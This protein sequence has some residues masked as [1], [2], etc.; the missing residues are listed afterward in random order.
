MTVA[1]SQSRKTFA[2]DNVSTSFGTTPVVFFETS[3]LVIYVTDDTTG[4]ATT[5]VENTDY[6]VTGGDGAVGTVSL[7]GGSSPWGALQTGTTL[8]IVRELPIVQEADPEN[9]DLSD[10]DVIEQ[11]LDRATMVSQQLST[12]LDRSIVFDDSVVSTAS[13]T[14]PAPEAD[15]FLG[16]NDTA[17]AIENK[18][19]A[20]VSAISLPVAIADG[21]TGQITAPLALAALGGQSSTEAANTVLARS[22]GTS[23]AMAGV[24]LAASQLLG[25]GA[26]GNVAA[27][28]LG[29]GLSM[30][31]TTLN[32]AAA[33]GSVTASGYTQ[34]TSRLLGRTTASSGAIEEISVGTGLSLSSGTLSASSSST[35]RTQW[36]TSF[37]GTSVTQPSGAAGYL[38]ENGLYQFTTA[39]TP[40]YTVAS[41]S[42]DL[43]SNGSVRNE[44]GIYWGA[45]PTFGTG[46]KASA[47]PTMVVRTCP[48]TANATDRF[49]GLAGAQISAASAPTN[50][51][52]FRFNTSGNYIFVC[53]ASGTESTVDTGTAATAGTLVNLSFVSSSNGTSIQAYVNGV[54]AGSPITTNIPSAALGFSYS[55]GPN[56]NTVGLRV[57]EIF[58]EQD[59]E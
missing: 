37:Q 25:R 6:T 53:R 31:G 40:T 51:I 57:A 2:G 52:Y 29:T 13:T 44:G 19:I 45:T 59:M 36:R 56:T 46:W 55:N 58:I 17:T 14:L 48:L 12:R 24:A 42:L 33:S 18:T 23:G 28:A 20:D 16:W 38:T 10:A 15:A 43:T 5:L 3:N 27:I 35:T 8:V 30:S 21:G 11:A 50:G 26:S 41:H 32:G 54:A 4:V 47:D 7:A 34:N 22:A 39:A 1:S 9:N 49:I